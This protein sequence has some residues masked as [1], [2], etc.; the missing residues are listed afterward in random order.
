MDWPSLGSPS[1]ASAPHSLRHPRSLPL[2]AEAAAW[3]LLAL[4][5]ESPSGAWREELAAVAAEVHDGELC[6]AASAAAVQ[7]GEGL[8]YTLF[9]PGG[10]VS[11]REISYRPTVDAGQFLAELADG[12]AAF[13]YHPAGYEPPDHLTI[14]AGFVAFLR[15]KEAFAEERGESSQAALAARCARDFVSEHLARFSKPLVSRLADMG[16]QYLAQAAAALL[17]Y[18]PPAPQVSGT[19]LEIVRAEE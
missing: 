2:L 14:E 9:G 5:F 7:A 11:L 19:A 6:A 17:R 8:Y 3:R 4:L 1:V 12:Y 16:I 10:P 13:G 15:L 18:A